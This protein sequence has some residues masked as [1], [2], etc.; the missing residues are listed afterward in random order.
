M[1]VLVDPAAVEFAMPDHD[2]AFSL[3]VPPGEYALK[4]FFEGKQVGK[5]EGLRVSERGLDL[6]EPIALVGDSK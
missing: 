4:V 5:E 6:K 1:Y 3:P 2:G